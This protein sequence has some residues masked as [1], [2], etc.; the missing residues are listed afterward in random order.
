TLPP[1]MELDATTGTIS[2]TPTQAGSWK[3]IT[4]KVATAT[5]EAQSNKFN[6]HVQ[7]APLGITQE[8]STWH[9]P[10]WAPFSTAAVTVTGGTAPYTFSLNDKEELPDGLSLDTATG[11]V[12]GTPPEPGNYSITLVAEDSTG[13]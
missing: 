12:S 3:D 11:T 8:Q 1:G 6:I 9:I 13:S 4:I 2:G 5:A 10:A 7:D